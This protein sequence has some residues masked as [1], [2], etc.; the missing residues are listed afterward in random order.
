MRMR[1]I[2][3]ISCLAL[4]FST[5][6]FSCT[7]FKNKEAQRETQKQIILNYWRVFDEPDAVNGVIAEYQKVHPNVS[8]M[9]RKLTFEEYEQKLVD[10][11]AEDKGPDLFSIHNTWVD[12]YRTKIL[13]MPKKLRVGFLV[14]KGAIKKI[15]V[16]E[17]VE[18]DSYTPKDIRNVFVPAVA[19]DVL[20]V[21]ANEEKIFG[22]PFS[23]DALSM[24][25]NPDLFNSAS[26]A[27]APKD[28]ITEF[29]D[30]VKKL[31]IINPETEELLQA[32]A[33]FGSAANVQ[34][35]PDII[36][37]LMM[38]RGARMAEGGSV[39]LDEMPPN[40]K[41][42]SILPSLDA[43][44]YYTDFAFNQSA[45]RTWDESYPDSFEAFSQGR[46]AIFFGYSYHAA[47]L[48][49]RFPQL[50]FRVAPLPQINSTRPVT[51]AN[52][53]IE[54]VSKKS[55]NSEYAWDFL[56]FA[57]TGG[58]EITSS[59]GKKTFVHHVQSYLT[60]SEKPTALRSLIQT[61]KQNENL[62]PFVSQLLFA[63]N[64]YHGKSPQVMEKALQDMITEGLTVKGGPEELG[65]LSGIIGRTKQIIQAEY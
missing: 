34:R 45:L 52:Y 13:P 24:F 50:K 27:D 33:A 65:R 43:L 55:P 19:E 49:N 21:E 3:F 36:A 18:L 16:P 9:V 62:N 28:W 47:Q 11:F 60:R 59:D 25:Y 30:A 63:K 7:L 26:V 1:F 12:K 4:I 38:Q 57:A 31:T 54:T 22:V 29:P 48:R 44:R 40:V 17:I 56:K 23:V 10:A 42:Q 51:T 53:W 39:K 32:G 41:D 46:A 2:L 5:S 15:V 35:A 14:E 6:G 8:I 20:R 37:S 61:Q 64:W 58:N